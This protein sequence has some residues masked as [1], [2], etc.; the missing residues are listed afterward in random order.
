MPTEI[1][2]GIDPQVT[3]RVTEDEG[4]LLLQVIADKPEETDIDAIFLNLTNAADVPA[5]TIYPT[6]NLDQVTAFEVNPGQLNQVSNGATLQDNYDV[7]VEFGSE[8]DST[9]GD[10]DLAVF[11]FW[12]DGGSGYLTA[13]SIDLDNLTVVVNSDN[14]AGQ[15]L[16]TGAG[17]TPAQV[18][19]VVTHSEDFDGLWNPTQ[20][21]DIVRADGWD[22][23]HG[24]L[25]TDGRNDGQLVFDEV[26][27][28]GPVEFA[29]D[30]RGVN[31]REFENSGRYEDSLRVEVQVDG[32]DWALLDEF[33]VN[34][35]GTA[36]VGSETGQTITSETSG[37]T[38][39]GGLLESASE[40]VQ[41]R[42]V[43]DMS[44]YNEQVRIDNVEIRATEM[45]D[46]K[47]DNLL[48]NGGLESSVAEGTWVANGDVAGWTSNNGGIEAWGDGFRGHDASEG[49]S[50]I[51]LDRHGAGQAVDRIHQDVQTEAGQ[52]YELSFDAAQRGHDSDH[53]EV[54]W[55]GTLMRTVS[56]E[57][58]DWENFSVTVTGT[59]AMDRL[60]FRELAS[61]NDSTGPLLDNIH[62]EETD[63]TIL[64]VNG[65]LES[66]V[67][68]RTWTPNG[69]VEGWTSNN[70][71]IEAWGN[72]FLGNQASEG[73]S[74]VELDRH[75]S[76]Q[77]I[78][79]IHQDVQTSEGETYTLTF[80]AA[81]R[82]HDS[83]SI[84]IY[85]NDTLV[86]TV[87]PDDTDWESFSV[88]VTGTGGMDRLEFR[89]LASEND[90]TGPLLDN[91]SLVEAG[92]DAGSSG[93]D[94]YAVTYEDIMAPPAE[95]DTP[96]EANADQNQ[97]D[98]ADMVG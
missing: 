60:E 8:P 12:V 81:Q 53:V 4:N 63:A 32:G 84:E 95:D 45:V 62:L 38:Y 44:A 20:S 82:G 57:D 49:D 28:D 70:G 24:E 98:M 89:E 51:E 87:S 76:G 14:G 5:L 80:D 54:Y 40:N 73:R 93:P 42:F 86:Q 46:V 19:V 34:D 6:V 92:D 29:F 21:N 9:A 31:I 55:N 48:V 59:G 15:A 39:T 72:G 85:W 74:F 90:S 16:T 2:L 25:H 33:Q 61:E 22:V 83:D 35:A 3:L 94:Q 91:I 58:T 41:F 11:T 56:P 30:A 88:D 97:D 36:L 18:P 10:Q 43:S 68:D 75:G 64:L 23:R 77:E 27:T 47:G 13:D 71:G 17:S 78:D 66:S 26:S 50:F 37:L 52:T 96:A 69:D 67:A 7:K 65:G 79:R 1:L